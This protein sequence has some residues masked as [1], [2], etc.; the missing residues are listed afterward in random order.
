[1]LWRTAT[2]WGVALLFEVDMESYN[3]LKNNSNLLDFTDGK[4]PTIVKIDNV[5]QW[6]ALKKEENGYPMSEFILK[7]PWESVLFVHSEPEF[8]Y[9]NGKVVKRP[10]ELRLN[11]SVLCMP[12]TK[13]NKY[14]ISYQVFGGKQ[15][16]ELSGCS[17][18]VGSGNVIEGEEG[19]TS[20]Y[21][22]IFVY[23]LTN[24]GESLQTAKELAHAAID[25]EAVYAN[26]AM[27]FI[28]SRNIKTADVLPNEKI[29]RKR[30][31]QGREPNEVYKII[32]IDALKKQS[33]QEAKE[34][35]ESEYK[36]ALHICRGHFRT[37]TEENKLFGKFT[38]KVWIPM[39]ERGDADNGKVHKDYTVKV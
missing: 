14:G 13:D 16:C 26:F 1:M 30:I 5:V 8:S 20:F 31:R 2:L 27:T 9:I 12:Y 37:Y 34:N 36:R 33:K 18:H 24:K 25:M 29:N 23:E 15:F 17:P 22:P 6:V 19:F 21:N 28:N 39:H 35:D 32:E 10:K 11:M 38:G 3:W 4:K 7:C